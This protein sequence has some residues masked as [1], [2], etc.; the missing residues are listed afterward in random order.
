MQ[1][2]HAGRPYLMLLLAFLMQNASIGMT[3]GVIGL[4]IDPVAKDLNT[5]RSTLSLSIALVALMLGLCGPLVGRLLD[6]WSVRGTMVLGCLI[7]ALGFYLTGSATSAN[8]YLMSFGLVVGLG[9]SMMGVMPANKIA[10]FWFPHMLGKASGIVNLPV[11]NALAPP[12]FGY[13]M[14]VL[15]WRDMLHVFAYVFIALTALA[16]LVRMPEQSAAAA[17]AEVGRPQGRAPF[18][19]AVFWLIALIAGLLNTSGIVAITHSVSYAMDNGATLAQ[20]TLILSVFGFGSMAG[21]FI[22]GWLCD[23]VGV[24]RA[25][26][27]NALMQAV[28]WLGVVALPDFNR[29]LPTLALLS[30]FTGGV[31]PLAVVAVGRAFPPH[32]FGAAMGQLTFALIPF[33]FGAAPLA[34]LLFDRSGNYVSAFVL[35]AVLCALALAV[36]LGGRALLRNSLESAPAAPAPDAQSA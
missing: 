6:R 5:G 22:C 17:V 14:V 18:R 11:L 24:L 13:L 26:S 16:L 23:R 34:G 20:G 30:F 15:G 25:L 19:Q 36:L 35:E 21:A 28:L 10:A 3:Y 1:N 7:C 29:L 12:L 27:L 4:L 2:P 33:N 32:Q 31:F 9:F 8:L